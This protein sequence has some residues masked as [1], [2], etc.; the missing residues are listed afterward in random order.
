MSSCLWTSTDL[1]H[2]S[3]KYRAHPW[4]LVCVESTSVLVTVVIRT[5][6]GVANLGQQCVSVTALPRLTYPIGISQYHAALF[7]PSVLSFFKVD[8]LLELGA[9]LLHIYAMVD[10]DNA[11]PQ[12]ILLPLPSPGA[13]PW[14]DLVTEKDIK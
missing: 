3:P 4:P 1:L 9:V 10:Q 12:P 11:Y 8:K 2:Q 6:R 14:E 5:H 13:A 7:G